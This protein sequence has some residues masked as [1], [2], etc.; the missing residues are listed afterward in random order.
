[1]RGLWFHTLI[2]SDSRFV[3]IAVTLKSQ[4][5]DCLLSSIVLGRVFPSCFFFLKPSSHLYNTQTWTHTISWGNMHEC[6]CAPHREQIFNRR[7]WETASGGFFST[8]S[9]QCGFWT[10]EYF[11]LPVNELQ[12][13]KFRWIGGG[14]QTHDRAHKPTWSSTTLSNQ[15]QT[16]HSI[17]SRNTAGVRLTQFP[18]NLKSYIML[19]RPVCTAAMWF[20]TRY[21]TLFICHLQKLHLSWRKLLFNILTIL[22]NHIISSN[23][24]HSRELQLASVFILDASAKYCTRMK[25]CILMC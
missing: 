23:E 13:E 16:H 3:Y 15:T 7:A 12:R 1:M 22:S 9:L 4:R 8:I 2:S 19:E 17:V 20:G 24:H 10:M 25:N 5:L 18:T 6:M 21:V 14:L 11:N